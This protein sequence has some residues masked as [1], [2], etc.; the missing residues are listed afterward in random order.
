[1]KFLSISV[2]FGLSSQVLAAPISLGNTLPTVSELTDGVTNIVAPGEGTVEGFVTPIGDRDVGA[3][4][5]NAGSNV[6]TTLGAVQTLQTDVGTEL[7]SLLAAVQGDNTLNVVPTILSGLQTITASLQT[8]QGATSVAG[9]AVPLSGDDVTSLTSTLQILK[10]LVPNIQSSLT[11]VVSALPANDRSL[12]SSDVSSVVNLIT[13][14]V[15]P[16][17]SFANST[18]G[19]MAGDSNVPEIQTLAGEVTSAVNS[20]LAPVDGLLQSLVLGV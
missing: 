16:I 12:V 15:Q 13:P 17:I 1:M 2:A 7:N 19:T 11:S 10:A 9:P 20:L 8:A 4:V 18:A 3:T 5:Q 14:T 6:M